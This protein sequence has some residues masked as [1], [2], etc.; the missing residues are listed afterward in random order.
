MFPF[1]PQAWGCTEGWY[2]FR[3]GRVF[4]TGVG[5]YRIDFWRASTVLDIPN[6]AVVFPTGVGVYRAS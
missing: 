4:P 2:L 6:T 5:V 3:I 1:S